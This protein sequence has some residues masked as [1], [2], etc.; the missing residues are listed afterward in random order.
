MQYIYTIKKEDI[1]KKYIR[2]KCKCC[3][4]IKHHID[5]YNFMGYIM[6][7]DVGKRIYQDK[8]QTYHVENDEQ[9]NK[10]LKKEGLNKCIT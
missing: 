5:I 1:N 6:P 2:I 4:K 8:F 7:C 10:R 9:L 3:N